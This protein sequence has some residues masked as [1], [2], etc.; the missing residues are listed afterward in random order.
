[1]GFWN[2]KE[3]HK[4]IHNKTLFPKRYEQDSDYDDYQRET[5]SRS[6]RFRHSNN[7][8][9]PYSLS[10]KRY[11]EITKTGCCI[12]G[13]KDVIDLHHKNGKED[14]SELVALCPNH[15]QMLHRQHLTFTEL[16]NRA[17]ILNYTCHDGH[18]E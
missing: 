9:P 18:W 14:E 10:V 8:T 11:K 7:N 17:T 6:Y 3:Y 2:E 13:F 4:S 16:I 12:C 5:R 1:M 15:H